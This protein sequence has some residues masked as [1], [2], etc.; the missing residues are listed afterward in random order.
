LK[1]GKLTPPSSQPRPATGRRAIHGGGN[2]GAGRLLEAFL[3]QAHPQT[4]TGCCQRRL[5]NREPG[6]PAGPSRIGAGE[7]LDRAPHR[8]AGVLKGPT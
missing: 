5:C 1:R 8:D 4:T 6:N 3:D 7:H 2:L